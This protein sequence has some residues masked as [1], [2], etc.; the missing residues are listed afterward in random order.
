M[1]DVAGEESAGAPVVETSQ[2]VLRCRVSHSCGVSD[3]LGPQVEVF[4]GS[5]ESRRRSSWACVG[6]CRQVRHPP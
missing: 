2:A 1:E 6:N 5:A 3:V 4:P